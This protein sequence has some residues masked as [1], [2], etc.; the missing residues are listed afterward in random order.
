MT[1]HM[2]DEQTKKRLLEAIRTKKMALQEKIDKYAEI[3]KG[4]EPCAKTLKE[5]FAPAEMSALWSRLA[6]L[7]T[8]SLTIRRASSLPP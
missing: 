2:D 8:V 3:F 1:T 4:R 5:H 6:T 7:G